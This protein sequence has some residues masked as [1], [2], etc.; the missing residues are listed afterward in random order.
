MN[1]DDRLLPSKTGFSNPVP[2]GFRA[3]KMTETRRVFCQ[4]YRRKRN[5]VSPNALTYT[6]FLLPTDFEASL[7]F[8]SF[9]SA[10]KPREDVI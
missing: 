7:L 3:E 9:T 4:K 8:S 1:R 10:Q 5:F 2:T 6:A